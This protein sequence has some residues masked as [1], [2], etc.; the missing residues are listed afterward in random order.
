M[1]SGSIH[2]VHKI[3]GRLNTLANNTGGKVISI[4]SFDEFSKDNV[5]VMRFPDVDAA[6]RLEYCILSNLYVS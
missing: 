5:A 2:S 6:Q 3:K 4:S 1:P